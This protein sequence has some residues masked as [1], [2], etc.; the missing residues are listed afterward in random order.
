MESSRTSAIIRPS[1]AFKQAQ[2]KITMVWLVSV[3][4]IALLLIVQ[5][6]G[7]EHEEIENEL[8]NWFYKF[9]I[10][11]FTIILGGF[12]GGM[13]KPNDENKYIDSIYYRIV[14]IL[15][16]FY[17]LIIL[18]VIISLPAIT[19]RSY[20][21]TLKVSELPLGILQGLVGLALGFFFIKTDSV[22]Q[23]E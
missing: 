23:K 19:D 6:L 7:G 10:P 13:N 21:E 9:N 1:I 14:L 12:F 4:A 5:T 3:I 16:V 17:L 2:A 15:S 20:L 11:T 22:A 18:L 8:W